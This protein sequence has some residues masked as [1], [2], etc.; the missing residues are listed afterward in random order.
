MPGVELD[1]LTHL[2]IH[3]SIHP[4]IW[5]DDKA[6]AES[7]VLC[8]GLGIRHSYTRFV[9]SQSPKSNEEDKFETY[10]YKSNS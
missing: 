5:E 8:L 1:T 6:P 7:L 2:F 9:I 4:F 10:F 3:P